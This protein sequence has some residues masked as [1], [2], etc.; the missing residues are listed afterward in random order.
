MSH[1]EPAAFRNVYL[2]TAQANHDRANASMPY[3]DI[4]IVKAPVPDGIRIRNQGQ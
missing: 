3:K 1:D 2:L 4:V